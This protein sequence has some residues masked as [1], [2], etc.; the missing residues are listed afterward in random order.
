MLKVDNISFGYD[1]NLIINNFHLDVK[2]GECIGIKG[3]SG[4]GKS[5]ILRLIAG[6]EKTMS[7]KIIIDGKDV[8]DTPTF[9]RNVGYVFQSFG[10]FPHLSVKNNILF[11]IKHLPKNERQKKLKNVV[12]M[13]EIDKYLDRF[14]HELSGGQKQRVAIARSLVIDP[15]IL[16]LDEPFSSLDSEIKEKIRVEIK[17]ILNKVGITTILVTHDI[18]DSNVICDRIV[19]I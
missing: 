7:G 5:T 13:L 11:G 12:K 9:N 8:T 19:E 10:L 2:K 17:T 3:N 14:P 1:Q 18:Q 15:K 6:L 16:L 4:T